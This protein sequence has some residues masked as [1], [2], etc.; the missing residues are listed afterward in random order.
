MH[1]HAHTHILTFTAIVTGIGTPSLMCWVFSLKS[2]Q[3][4]PMFT[5]R[6]SVSSVQGGREQGGR[7][8]ITDCKLSVTSNRY[9]KGD[10]EFVSIQTRMP[11]AIEAR[12]CYSSGCTHSRGILFYLW[13]MHVPHAH[14]HTSSALLLSDSLYLS[15]GWTKGRR[16][17]RLPGW[18][19]HPQ[20]SDHLHHSSTSSHFVTKTFCATL[21][22]LQYPEC[23]WLLALCVF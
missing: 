15:Q 10:H 2:L 21:R 4:F 22:P 18:S 1:T 16:R 11:L 7:Y 5:P 19:V 23:R 3:N 8:H 9:V 20:L 14:V 12:A 6:C 13:C 17:R